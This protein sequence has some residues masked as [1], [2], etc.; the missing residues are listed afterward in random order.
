MSKST[1]LTFLH[2]LITASVICVNLK[3]DQRRFCVPCKCH[4]TIMCHTG[5]WFDDKKKQNG[6][7]TAKKKIEESHQ[8]INLI[9]YDKKKC[10][11]KMLLL[12]SKTVGLLLYF[13]LL[14]TVYEHLWQ[15]WSN[16]RRGLKQMTR[17]A[18][19][20]LVHLPFSKNKS[21]PSKAVSAV[22]R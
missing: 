15:V 7:A 21:C 6:A 8:D 4:H 2:F 9:V 12:S 11:K 13:R 1:Y 18:N 22:I 17:S 19:D 20:S 16:F 10:K 14:H 3:W 5:L